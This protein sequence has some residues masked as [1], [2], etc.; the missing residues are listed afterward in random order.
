MEMEHGGRN[1][2]HKWEREGKPQRS[3]DGRGEVA[4]STTRD[5]RHAKWRGAEATAASVRRV[6]RRVNME[7]RC[8]GGEQGTSRGNW[9]GWPGHGHERAVF[10]FF[11]LLLFTLVKCPCVA[12]AHK[13][14]MHND[15][16]KT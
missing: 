1:G 7:V 16:I 12:T 8:E 14:F 9:N 3:V 15:Y 11:S 10:L 6:N 13:L 5:P 4:V 2:R